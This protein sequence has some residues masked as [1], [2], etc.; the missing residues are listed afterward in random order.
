MVNHLPEEKLATQKK[1]H[2]RGK[3]LYDGDEKFYMK[4]VTYGTFAPDED[5]VQFPV[6]S[7]VERDFDLMSK[8][9]FNCVRTYTVPPQHVLDL[10]VLHNLKLMVGLPWEQ[11][12]TFLDSKKHSR[13]IIRRVKESVEACMQHPSILCYSIGNEI[14]ATVV[15]WYGPEKIQNFLKK[16]YKAVKSVDPDTLVTYVNYPTTEYLNLEF[17][18]FDCWNVY[19]ET[20]EKMSGYLARL[21]NLSGDRPMVLAE[22]GLDSMRNGGVRQAE[23]LR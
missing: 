21:Q 10:A 5:D 14:P 16:L 2:V 20:P 8:N 11:H 12:I 17:L 13:D 9:G 15:R 4:G 19:L 18:D 1:V 22:I 7:V 23:V 3:F 6:R